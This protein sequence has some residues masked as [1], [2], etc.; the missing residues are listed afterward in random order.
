MKVFRISG[1]DGRFSNNQGIRLITASMK[2]FR[3]SGRD[4]V[5]DCGVDVVAVA[6]MKVFRIS[7]RD[8]ALFCCM[9]V[10]ALA[11]MKVFRISRRDRAVKGIT[12]RQRRCLNESLPHKQKRWLEASI[13]E[14]NGMGP[15]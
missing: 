15:Q 11:S 9:I 4:A 5:Q 2:V 6:S 12:P 10:G 13:L 1:R 7:R 14:R 3:I 8:F